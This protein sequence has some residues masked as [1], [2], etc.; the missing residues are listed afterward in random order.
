[1]DPNPGE[2]GEDSPL[3][4]FPTFLQTFSSPFGSSFVNYPWGPKP[5]QHQPTKGPS[6]PSREVGVPLLPWLWNPHLPS[7]DFSPGHTSQNSWNYSTTGSPQAVWKGSQSSVK[8]LYFTIFL[9]VGPFSDVLLLFFRIQ[10]LTLGMFLR[11]KPWGRAWSVKIS[12]GTW[13][14]FIQK[15]GDT[16]T[17]LL[18]ER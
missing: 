5:A 6:K 7:D 1:M 16:T 13:T 3:F 4:Y 15:W 18:M 2:L 12:S 9:E 17:P 10:G 14:M 11:G 8:Y